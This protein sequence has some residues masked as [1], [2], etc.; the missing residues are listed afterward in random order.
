MRIGK[1]KLKTENFMAFEI[2][3]FVTKER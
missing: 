3:H 1:K 2:S